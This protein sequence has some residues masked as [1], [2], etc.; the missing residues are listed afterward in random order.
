MN[1]NYL[2]KKK[3]LEKQIA[4]DEEKVYK[5]HYKI[6]KLKRE[7]KNEKRKLNIKNRDSSWKKRNHTLIRKGALLEIANILEE[8]NSILLGYF[9]KF[10]NLTETQKED[11]RVT[12]T[13]EFRR[14]QGKKAN[15]EKRERE[16]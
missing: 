10:N 15:K 6:E 13:L 1:S 9:L 8:E 3:Q 11:C 16:E 5:L 7:V 2:D 14:R 4:E 12:G